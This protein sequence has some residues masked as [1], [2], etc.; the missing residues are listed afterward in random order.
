MRSGTGR[1]SAQWGL[2]EVTAGKTGTT[3]GL[4]DAWF[5]GYTPDLVVGVWVGHDD[6]T[7]LGLTGA[8]AALPIWAGVMQV[9]VRRRPPRAF[10][11]PEG[12]V[13]GSCQGSPFQRIGSEV[14]GWVTN[15]F[16]RTQAAVP[17]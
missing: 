17:R 12:V 2:S 5:V 8:Q 1:S 4:R 13:F 9:A 7:P 16:R 3:D 15:L 11:A 10:A 14:L 6:G